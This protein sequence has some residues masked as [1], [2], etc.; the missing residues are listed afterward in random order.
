MLQLK[1]IAR[2][3]IPNALVKAERYR[4][5]HQP[6]EAESICRDVLGA[7]SQNQK[8]LVTLL[9]SLTDQFG[10]E[11][12]VHMDEA[13]QFLPRLQDEYERNYYEGLVVERWGKAQC[14]RGTPRYVL[15]DWLRKAMS[16]YEKAEAI[17]PPGNDEAIL[18]WNACCRIIQRDMRHDENLA[19]PTTL[20]E[21]AGFE[22]EAPGT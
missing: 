4:L 16:C 9:L 14:S 18:R 2:E 22:D 3:A 21:E 17:R 19:R 1:P 11:F 13:R 12:H 20:G 6:Q 8:A 15:H 10:R 5:L 7:D